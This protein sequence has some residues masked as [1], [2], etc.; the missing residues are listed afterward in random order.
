MRKVRELAENV[1]YIVNTSANNGELLFESAFGVWLFGRTVSEAKE[2]FAFELRGVRF[3]GATVSF[4]IKPA[5][6]LQLPE[7]MKWIKQ[8]CGYIWMMEDRAISGATGTGQ[9]YS[10]VSRL[11]VRRSMCLWKWIV[12]YGGELEAGGGEAG[13]GTGGGNRAS[14]TCA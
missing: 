7:I 6:G 10:P 9:R 4:F 12:R 1:W 2:R 14:R 5:N 11:N 3:A 13:T 8:T